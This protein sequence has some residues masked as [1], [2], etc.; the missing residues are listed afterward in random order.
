MVFLILL[1]VSDFLWRL[2]PHLFNDLFIFSGLI[3]IVIRSSGLP[4]AIFTAVF[5]FF[6]IGTILF[7]LIRVF[8]TGLGGGDLKM[9]A[10]LTVWMGLLKAL[11][12]L[13]FACVTASLFFFI[14]L[15]SNRVRWKWMIP[16]GPFL[17]I[18]ALIFWFFPNLGDDFLR[19]VFLKG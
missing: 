14:L 15:M 16:F 6:I 18:G 10:G 13:V 9:L 12:V 4:S 2:L 7:G 11:W 1:T 8:P 5:G 17:A 19:K 3:F